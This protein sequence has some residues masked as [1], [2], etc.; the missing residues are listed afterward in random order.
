MTGPD[1]GELQRILNA[2]Y[3][4]K[5]GRRAL[6]VDNSYG[7]ATEARV[8]YLQQRARIT[9][10]GIAGPQTFATLNVT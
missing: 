8:R 6:V 1:V 9:V 5:P 3:P 10:D 7:P 2:W 4:S